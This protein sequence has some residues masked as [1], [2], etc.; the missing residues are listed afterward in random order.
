MRYRLDELAK[1]ASELGLETRRVDPDRID[2]HLGDAVLAF[3]NFPND[4]D[5]LVG[6]DGTPWHAHNVVVFMTGE[7]SYI[8]CDEL[9]ILIGLGAGELVI[10]SKYVNGILRDRWLAHREEPLRMR[11]IEPGEELRVSRLP[12]RAQPA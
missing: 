12:Y 1:L 7:S 11:Y 8:Q 3:C 2:V 4:E 6:F 10:V 9:D 5:T